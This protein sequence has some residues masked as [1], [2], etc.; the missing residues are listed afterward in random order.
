MI[1]S[2]HYFGLKVRNVDTSA[3]WYEEVLGFQRTGEYTTPGGA[4][5]KVFLRD[6]GLQARLGLTQHWHAARTHST[7]RAPAWTT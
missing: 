2:V 3:T 6:D 1:S 7:K 5:R 4:R